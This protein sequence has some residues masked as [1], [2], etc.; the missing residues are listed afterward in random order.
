MG[1]FCKK[2]N[3]LSASLVRIPTEW[4]RFSFRDTVNRNFA[5]GNN[6]RHGSIVVAF[7][8]YVVQPV[9]LCCHIV[10]NISQTIST[11]YLS[12]HHGDKLQSPGGFSERSATIHAFL[13]LKAYSS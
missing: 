7:S 10:H 1:E 6:D 3:Q 4:R 2:I 12:N 11:G 9:H 5:H 13:M 8:V